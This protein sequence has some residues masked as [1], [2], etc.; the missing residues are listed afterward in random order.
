[1]AQQRSC[2]APHIKGSTCAQ[3]RNPFSILQIYFFTILQTKSKLLLLF[4]RPAERET[5][6]E[7]KWPLLN[8]ETNYLAVKNDDE[9]EPG[10]PDLSL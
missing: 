9:A 10:L 5:F 2:V 4:S 7:K 8:L 3:F 1:V 6:G